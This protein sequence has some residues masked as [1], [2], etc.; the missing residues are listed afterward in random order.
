MWVIVLPVTGIVLVALFT[1]FCVCRYTCRFISFCTKQCEKGHTSNKPVTVVMPSHQDIQELM[2]RQSSPYRNGK[3]VLPSAPTD[4]E[5]ALLSVELSNCLSLS[6]SSEM[7]NSSA[8]NYNTANSETTKRLI[9]K[10][11]MLKVNGSDRKQND[12]TLQMD[13]SSD[14]LNIMSSSRSD[15]NCANNEISEIEAPTVRITVCE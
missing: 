4:E 8:H 10:H 1:V 13:Y 11:K 3:C 6:K 7:D 15:I 14:E 2:Q 5:K 12:I 9:T